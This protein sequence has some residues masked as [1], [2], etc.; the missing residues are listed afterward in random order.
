MRRC[1]ALVLLLVALTG[2][3]ACAT[4]V[5]NTVIGDGPLPL[6]A[7]EDAL[8]AQRRDCPATISLIDESVKSPPLTGIGNQVVRSVALE[9]LEGL[10]PEITESQGESD[11]QVVVKR[12]YVH[13]LASSKSAVVVL[14]VTNRETAE[15]TVY[16]GRSVGVNWWGTQREYLEGLKLAMQEALGPVTYQLQRICAS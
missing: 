12:A 14:S 4:K 1:S 6:V 3:P 16:R 10:G 11:L 13:N 15:S 5:S 2:I 9:L 7:G 8:T